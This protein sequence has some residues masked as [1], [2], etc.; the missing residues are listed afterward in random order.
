MGAIDHKTCGHVDHTT[1][2]ASRHKEIHSAILGLILEWSSE[3]GRL[4]HVEFEKHHANL[5]REC[6]QDLVDAMRPFEVE[7]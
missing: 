4:E 6:V 7:Q 5:K 2:D 3:A 1:L